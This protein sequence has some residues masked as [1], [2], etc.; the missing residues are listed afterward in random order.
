VSGGDH[1]LFKRS[2]G[3]KKPVTRK[4]N[5]ILIIIMSIWPFVMKAFRGAEI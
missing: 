4:N 1:R 3:K 2:T 5:I